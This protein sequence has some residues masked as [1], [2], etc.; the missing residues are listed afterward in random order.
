M[1]GSCNGFSPTGELYSM[2]DTR[3]SCG[4]HVNSGTQVPNK[5]RLGCRGAWA[6]NQ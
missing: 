6:I 5:E 3:P 1:I 2:Q 4:E